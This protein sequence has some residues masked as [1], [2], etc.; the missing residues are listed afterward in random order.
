MKDAKKPFESFWKERLQRELQP[1]DK[2]D[3][4]SVAG[5]YKP[6]TF[7]IHHIKDDSIRVITS[8]K[9]PQHIM[10]YDFEDIYDQWE[11]YLEGDILRIKLSR[12]NRFTTYIFSIF[13]KLCL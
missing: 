10:K 7:T 5:R 2:I 8:D 11:G 9:K 12:H 1:G 3:H 13:H 6:L 4:W